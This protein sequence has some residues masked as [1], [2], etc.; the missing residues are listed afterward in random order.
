MKPEF[1]CLLLCHL[2]WEKVAEG[3]MRAAT[4]VKHQLYIFRII[5]QTS[6][7]LNLEAQLMTLVEALKQFNRK[8]R[9]WLIQQALGKPQ[10][11]AKFLTELSLALN[12]QCG[13][14]S[15]IRIP[16]NAYWAIDYHFDWIAGA[17]ESIAM[18]KEPFPNSPSNKQLV[19]G[20]QEDIDLLV[21]YEHTLILVECKAGESWSI[22]QLK[23]KKNRICLIKKLIIEKGLGIDIHKAIVSSD[24]PS[25]S[26]G[27]IKDELKG[28][29]WFKLAD[30]DLNS[31]KKPQRCNGMGDAKASGKYWQVIHVKRANS[32]V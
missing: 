12:K 5:P 26:R 31:F 25:E 22:K 14:K 7:N 16:E 3:R 11:D 8:E 17:L 29:P 13:D 24:D 2:A 6:D 30:Y 21:A 27:K 19:R 18:A 28:F 32:K 20:N 9:Y 4:A 15:K 10:L 1:N 23:S